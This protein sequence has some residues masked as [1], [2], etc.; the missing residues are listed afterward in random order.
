[1]WPSRLSSKLGYQSMLFDKWLDLLLSSLELVLEWAVFQVQRVLKV[2]VGYWSLGIEGEVLLWHKMGV[3]TRQKRR[4][5][6]RAK[7]LSS[8]RFQWRFEWKIW[9]RP[10]FAYNVTS[11][12]HKSQLKSMHF[13]YLRSFNTLLQVI[14]TELVFGWSREVQNKW[15]QELQGKDRPWWYVFMNICSLTEQWW[16]KQ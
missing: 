11:R 4:E 8:C 16:V 9:C 1:M 13:Q 3:K 14:Q 2:K 6:S 15:L 10:R 12:V 7:G 5:G